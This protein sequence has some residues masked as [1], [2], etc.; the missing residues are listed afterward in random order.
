MFF[1]ADAADA[2]WTIIKSDDE[3][4]ARLNCMRHFLSTLDHPGK[5]KKIAH[6]PDPLIVGHAAHVVHR[7]ENIL[8]TSLHPDPRR[9]TDA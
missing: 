7:S 9:G 4:G 6:A 1:Y 2:P 3:K 8:G 5:D